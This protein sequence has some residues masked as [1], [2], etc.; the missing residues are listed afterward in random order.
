MIGVVPPSTRARRLARA[1]LLLLCLTP[2]IAAGGS[3]SATPVQVTAKDFRF[4]L[5]RKQVPPGPVRF[6]VRNDGFEL[7][8]L[9]VAGAKT[10][11]L[12]HGKQATL[13]VRLPK[14]GRYR[15]FCTVPGH[16][17]LGMQA[18]L[19]VGR[20]P[21]ISPSTKTPPP[22]ASAAALTEIARLPSP[23]FLTAPPG[24][25]H[26]VFVVEKR[27]VVEELVDGEPRPQPFLD[28]SDE[29][30]DEGENGLLSMAF[31]PDYAASG[32]LYVVFN[33]RTPD[34]DLELREYRRSVADAHA[35][36]ATSARTVLT[37]RKPFA[38]HNGGMLQFGPDGYLYLSVGDGDSG[39]LHTPGFF[40]QTLD[41]LLG[42]V[43]R[44]DPLHPDAGPYGIPDGN[45]F[46][47]VAGA[48]PEIWAYGLR[49]PWR[50][51]IDPPTGDLYLGDVGL[52][53]PEEIDYVAGTAGRGKNF[54]WPCFEGS[55]LFDASASCEDPLPPV[56][57]YLRGRNQCALIGGVVVR[58]PHLSGL[59]GRYV[60]TDYCEGEL[61]S[62][63]VESGRAT[64]V[65]DL[66]LSV[67]M[68]DSFGVDGLGRVY[69]LS[70]E[71]GVYRLDPK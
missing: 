60:F 19:V 20:P 65:R 37:I 59:A 12:A 31:A 41:D 51:W 39:E 44:I 18:T 52:S 10:R 43:L 69:V 68:P 45:P 53:G 50:F 32:L 6:T 2:A 58:D 26:G 1:S 62:L 64:E 54:G 4:V 8:D 9:A 35:V 27:G 22:P 57:E 46:V 24:D 61:R 7:H 11:L 14:P 29:V 71:G 33:A 23:T 38:N 16:A 70:G 67:P 47:G 49:N 48:R 56:Y 5:S 30:A 3:A 36:D 55:R 17:R 40:A 15:L 13:E 66:G 34:K 28:L 25:E 42:N 63:R 21:P